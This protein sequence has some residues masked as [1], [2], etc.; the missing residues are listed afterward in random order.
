MTIDE[1]IESQ[2][3][4]PLYDFAFMGTKEFYETKI[5][6]LADMSE[7][8]VW[9]STNENDLD[10]LKNYIRETFGQI[11]SQNKLMYNR[12]K[13]IAI[14]NTGLLTDNSEQIFGLFKKI[15]LNNSQ[16]DMKDWIFKYFVKESSR[17][18]TN[19]FSEM[20]K[21]ATY[22]ENP[23]DFYFDSNSDIAL[24][25]DHILD[26]NWDRYPEDVKSMGKRVVASLV[27]DAFEI[28]KKKVRRNNRLVV[29]QFYH[30]QIMYLMPI[31]LNIAENKKITLAL[32]IEKTKMNTY[33]ANTIFTLDMAYTKARLIMK[34]ESNW[35]IKKEPK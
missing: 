15:E 32:A 17:E 33:R 35:L 4:N 21:L 31:D 1:K 9:Y 12:E 23:N 26:D 27:R 7:E 22:T 29:P 13:D 3:S 11:Q 19:N 10:R 18:I 34:P 5:K 14:F 30:D 8:E 24:N 6:E 25:S 2:N 28:A 16:K 20:P